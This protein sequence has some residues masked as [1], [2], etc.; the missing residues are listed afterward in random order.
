MR[1][2]LLIGLGLS[3]LLAVVVSPFA[4]EHP[5]GLERVAE[6][7]HFHERATEIWRR[8]PLPDYAAPLAFLDGRP[9]LQTGA[10]GG[11]G[12]LVVFAVLFGAGRF[13]NKTRCA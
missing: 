9:A 12:T 13:L 4:S 6:D 3:L 2:F 1:L 8:A 7:Q 5:D 11:I 10:A